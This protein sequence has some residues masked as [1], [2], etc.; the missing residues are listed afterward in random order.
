[1]ISMEAFDLVARGGALALMAMLAAVLV[2]DYRQ[3][4]A[5]QMAVLLLI[6]VSCHVVA[7]SAIMRAPSSLLHVL[8]VVGESSISGFFWLFVRSWFNDETRFGG[9]SWALIIFT[10]IVSM[11]NIL[12]FKYDSEVF[13][14]TDILMRGLWVG[15]VIAGLTV[16]WRGRENDLVEARR[17]MRAVFVWTVGAALI[18]V[19]AIYFYTNVIGHQRASVFVSMAIIFGIAIL[20]LLLGVALLGVRRVDLF[21]LVKP[22]LPSPVSSDDPTGNALAERIDQYMW[23]ERAWRDETLT[24]AKL[25]LQ[26]GAQEYRLRRVINGAMGHRNFA[27]F[28]N[29]YRLQEVKAA[30]ADP[31]QRDVPILTIALDAGFGSLGPFNRAFREAE[32]MT[33]TV[34]RS[35][36]TG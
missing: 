2:R 14:P 11:F 12:S 1:M 30:L 31:T 20:S 5:A 25:A 19:N 23:T 18:A 9:R 29:G 16:A 24:I 13:W 21:A 6:G 32:A 3:T 36:A 26:V 4:C 17:R 33:P 35:N 10:L 15:L 7:E 28:V 22:D 8:L 27:A 34:Y